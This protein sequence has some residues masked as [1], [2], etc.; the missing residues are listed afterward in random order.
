M[1]ALIV[2]E[3]ARLLGV[4]ASGLRL[5]EGD[6]LVLRA[7]TESAA[8]IMSRPRLKVGE[9]LSGLVVVRNE[10]IVV[11]DLVRDKRYDAAHKRAATEH[12]FHGF[13]AVPLRANA[14][15]IGVLNLYSKQRRRFGE[16]EVRL[17]GAL[18]DQASLA[19]E[20]DRLLR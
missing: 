3:A 9:S 13:L 10:P 1:L 2:N 8:A 6:E 19:I 18:A 5:V 11:E 15:V 16:D 7:W 14:T 4:E 12:G 17:A 20:R